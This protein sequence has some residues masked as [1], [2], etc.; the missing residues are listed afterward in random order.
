MKLCQHR[1]IGKK[2][3]S[4]CELWA[5]LRGQQQVPFSILFSIL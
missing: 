2:S 3:V 4:L 1:R 5:F